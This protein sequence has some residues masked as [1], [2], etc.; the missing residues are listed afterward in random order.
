MS[1][2]HDALGYYPGA[3]YVPGGPVGQT[4]P[5][6]MTKQWD[7]SVVVPSTESYGIKAP[8]YTDGTRFRFDCARSTVQ[9]ARC[10]ATR[11]GEP[12]WAT[13]AAP[14]TPAT[15]DGQYGWHVQLIEEAADHTWGKVKIW[16][17]AIGKTVGPAPAN[18]TAPGTYWFTYTVAW[19]DMG[20]VAAPV[21]V[22]M[23][24]PAG[25]NFVSGGPSG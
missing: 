24:L 18:I 9:S 6:W 20:S 14:A 25:L 23:T 17:V 2:F 1:A 7:A 5:R 15:V 4:T 8:G 21:N 19:T 11:Y 10:C 3:E 12:A 13:M 16:N 22:T